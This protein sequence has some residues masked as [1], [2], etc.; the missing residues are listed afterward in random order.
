M[1][2]Q[3]G[4]HLPSVLTAADHQ[5]IALSGNTFLPGDLIGHPSHMPQNGCFT[6]RQGG[7][8]FDMPL[9]Y[10][11]HMCGRQRIYIP[12]GYNLLILVKRIAGKLAGHNATENTFQGLTSLLPVFGFALLEQVISIDVI[13][14]NGREIIHR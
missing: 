7:Q 1:H 11:Q 2:M 13:G 3:M 12:E 8:R 4:H 9:R 5:A 14:H 6:I 10:Y